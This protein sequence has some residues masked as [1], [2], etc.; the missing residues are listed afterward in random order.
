MNTQARPG[1]SVKYFLS[2][3]INGLFLFFSCDAVSIGAGQRASLL[4]TMCA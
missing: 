3:K 2:L 4:S 1:E